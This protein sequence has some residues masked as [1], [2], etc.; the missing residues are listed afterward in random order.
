M[1]RKFLQI[2]PKAA[3]QGAKNTVSAAPA[4]PSATDIDT[5]TFQLSS[6]T[7]SLRTC[8][9]FNISFDFPI[10]FQM[11]SHKYLVED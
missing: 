11:K 8:T 1:G 5:R 6:L 3:S 10:S 4:A 7:T 9:S 2:S